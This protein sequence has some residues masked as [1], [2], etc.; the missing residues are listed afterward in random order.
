MAT[1]TNLGRVRGAGI[2]FSSVTSATSIAT[3]S[4]TPTNI[5]PLVGDS[6]LFNNGDIRTVTAI[7]STTI[8]CGSV[9]ANIKGAT[10]ATGPAGPA[11]TDGIPIKVYR[12]LV[13]V[14]GY[15]TGPI[16]AEI[17]S[18]SIATPFTA[19]TLLSWLKEN[20]Y[21]YYYPYPATGIVDKTTTKPSGSSS[22]IEV[23]NE[24]IGIC[25]YEDEPDE[26]G[27]V[28]EHLD[29]VYFKYN[30][31]GYSSKTNGTVSSVKDTVKEMGY[32]EPV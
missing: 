17:L 25:C 22:Y 15:A 16:E 14:T 32:A 27:Y 13:T 5:S 12:H 31:L 21:K 30:S 10:G 1:Q 19:T 3:S 29:F 24:A 18:N 9:Q 4:I 6:I 7:N 8:T 26:D 23:T 20:G 11:G 28:Y 2:F